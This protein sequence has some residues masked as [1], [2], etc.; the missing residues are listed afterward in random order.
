[1]ALLKYVFVCV[2]EPP[3]TSGNR[4]TSL[5]GTSVD[6]SVVSFIRRLI[7]TELGYIFDHVM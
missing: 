6:T 5:P 2:R 7:F 3:T 1:M 4:Q